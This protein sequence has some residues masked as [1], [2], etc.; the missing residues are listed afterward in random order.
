M[1]VSGTTSTEPTPAPYVPDEELMQRMFQAVLDGHPTVAMQL[2]G[3]LQLGWTAYDIGRLN[4]WINYYGPMETS[5]DGLT[6]LVQSLI[7]NHQSAVVPINDGMR[8]FI[9]QAVAKMTAN[10]QPPDSEMQ[11]IINKVLNGQELSEAEQSKLYQWCLSAKEV[12]IPADKRI[13]TLS[14]TM[15]GLKDAYDQYLQ[16]INNNI[17]AFVPR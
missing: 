7:Q 15:K 13:G 6:T 3:T 17:L 9:N 1:S 14:E 5:A 16:T 12:V 11:A 8:A 10:G 2:A 4:E